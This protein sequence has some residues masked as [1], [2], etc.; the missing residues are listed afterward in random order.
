MRT[1]TSSD[2][3]AIAF[4]RSG[5]G[6]AV[7][8]V[9]GA[10]G[11]R[12]SGPMGPLAP[13]LAPHF[14]VFMYDRRGRGDSGDTAPHAVAR[15]VEDLDALITAAGGS[16]FV[17]GISSGAALALEAAASGLAITKLAL[18][19]AP[20]IVDDSRPP[21]PAD[22]VPHLID[23][24]A[25][26]RRGDAVELFMTQAVGMP[27][28]AV[29]PMRRAPRWPGLEAVAHTLVYDGTIMGDC[30]APIER[31][32]SVTIPTLVMDGGASPVQMRNAAQAVAAALPS[33]QRRTLDGQTHDVAAAV[34]AP[35]LVEFFTAR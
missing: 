31:A 18:Y 11:S 7:I 30:S 32:A 34:L 16:A 2:G 23:L 28:E 20:F 22:Y 4:E 10:L 9:D 27:V 8:L 6:P 15:E 1:V 24:I 29:A 19:E 35:V 12:A 3:T 14:T 21:V 26:G 13:L 25:A 17:Y 33:A 5:E